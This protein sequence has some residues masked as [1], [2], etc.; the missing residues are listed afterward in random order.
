MQGARLTILTR[1]WRKMLDHRR[2]PYM[3]ALAIPSIQVR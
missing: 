3:S 2:R 1:H